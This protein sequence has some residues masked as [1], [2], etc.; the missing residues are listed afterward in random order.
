VHS[1][2][3]DDAGEAEISFIAIVPGTFTL[4]IPGTEGE[5]QRASFTIR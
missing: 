5:S 3:F 1:L 2:E 4:S